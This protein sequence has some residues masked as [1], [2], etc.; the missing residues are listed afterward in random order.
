MRRQH[1][2]S[3]ALETYSPAEEQFNRR[4]RT[5]GLLAGPALCI[6]ILVM[7]L[8]LPRPAHH[9]AAIMALLIE[10]MAPMSLTPASGVWANWA[11]CPAAMLASVVAIGPVVEMDC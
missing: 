4:R 11:C 3:G 9:L 2:P 8:G 10:V 6:L 5:F 7:P 1:E